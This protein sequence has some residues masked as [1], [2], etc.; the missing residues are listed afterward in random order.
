MYILVWGFL[1]LA[2][3]LTIGVFA[4]IAAGVV[5]CVKNPDKVNKIFD[6]IAK[7]INFEPSDTPYDT[8]SIFDED[9]YF[10]ANKFEDETSIACFGSN[11]GDFKAFHLSG[12]L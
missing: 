8:D 10:D 5:Y 6:N 12:R 4:A 11:G 1:I 2:L 9:E 7:A 3:L